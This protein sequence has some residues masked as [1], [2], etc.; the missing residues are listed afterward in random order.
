MLIG[1]LVYI[2]A[3]ISAN[4]TI[5]HF[6]PQAT[7]LVALVF[8]GLDLTLRNVL[9]VKMEPP[10]MLALITFAGLLSYALNPASGM[11]AVGSLCAFVASAL[12]DWS[13]FRRVSGTWFERCYAGVLVGALVDSLVF[14]T[15]AF[16]A[17]MPKIMLMQLIAK[18]GGGLLWAF[19]ISRFFRK[20]VAYA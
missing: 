17:I 1:V 5:A 18:A 19:A 8:I 20:E 12:A 14:P 15:I 2:I 3:I 16:G 6:G 4:T 9:G 7:G 10:K 13:T 11:I